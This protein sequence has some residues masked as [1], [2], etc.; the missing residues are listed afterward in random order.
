[1]SLPSDLP[2]NQPTNQPSIHPISPPINLPTGPLATAAVMV[3]M[4]VLF[5]DMNMCGKMV[6]MEAYDEK[7]DAST[8]N[9]ESMTQPRTAIVRQLLSCRVTL[10]WEVPISDKG[11]EN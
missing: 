10:G 1:L 9:P 11:H 4:M 8:F 2:T 6:N 3:P 7:S 5:F